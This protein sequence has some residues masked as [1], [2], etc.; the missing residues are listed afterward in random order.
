MLESSLL[1]YGAISD[2][3]FRFCFE[4]QCYYHRVHSFYEAILWED[5]SYSLS[6]TI[7]RWKCHTNSH[8][9][10]LLSGIMQVAGSYLITS[11]PIFHECT[12]KH[13]LRVNGPPNLAQKQ[14]STKSTR[15]CRRTQVFHSKSYR[16]LITMY[17]PGKV[18]TPFKIGFPTD[19]K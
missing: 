1:F 9:R 5:L 4:S 15:F 16:Q 3:L 19:T 17:S 7:S 6:D 8:I 11:D 12:C 18:L 2:F 14:S 13:R 10:F